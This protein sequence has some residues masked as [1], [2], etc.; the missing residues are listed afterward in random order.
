MVIG[1]KQNF[2]NESE[3]YLDMLK[4]RINKT[5]FSIDYIQE[6]KVLD[7][8]Y[9]AEKYFDINSNLKIL[10]FGCGI[11]LSIPYLRKHFKNSILYGCDYSKKSIEKCIETNKNINNLH[12]LSSNGVDIPFLE[13]FDIIFIA[14]VMRH[15]PRKNQEIVLKNLKACLKENGFIMMYEFN[16]FNPVSLYFYSIEDCKYDPE[17]VKIMSPVYSKN[18]FESIGFKNIKLNYRFFVPNSFKF[19]VG[20]EKYLKK[21]PFGA[22]YYLSA[23]I[24]N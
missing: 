3:I 21:V 13:K 12:L 2:D 15:I 1:Q 7:L 4:Y 6:Y 5:G 16:P 23:N 19:L 22:S 18:L 14:N 8:K 11:G 24:K 9:E 20:I 10:D 17:N